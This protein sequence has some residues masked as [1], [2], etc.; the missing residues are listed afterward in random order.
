[1][2][3]NGTNDSPNDED[4]R[5]LRFYETELDKQFEGDQR[6]QS[7]D[8]IVRG[9]PGQHFEVRNIEDQVIETASRVARIPKETG[10]TPEEIRAI[11]RLPDRYR[12]TRARIQQAIQLSPTPSDMGASGG[13]PALAQDSLAIRSEHT[14]FVSDL[15]TAAEST[16]APPQPGTR[17]KHHQSTQSET[18]TN[19]FDSSTANLALRFSEPTACGP[20]IGAQVV[21]KKTSQPNSLASP[22]HST[23]QQISEFLKGYQHTEERSE[24]S[25]ASGRSP[26]SKKVSF[27]LPDE[28]NSRETLRSSEE[29]SFKSA[30]DSL[31]EQEFPSNASGVRTSRTHGSV[32]ARSRPASV[33]ASRP[34]SSTLTSSAT[35]HNRPVSQMLRSSTPHALNLMTHR[36]EPRA[37][38]HQSAQKESLSF[39]PALRQ[40]KPSGSASSSTSSAVQSLSSAPHQDSITLTK[41]QKPKR[42]SS[43]FS[44]QSSRP[45]LFNRVRTRSTR[46]K[47]AQLGG[48]DLQAGEFTR[49]KENHAD[50]APSVLP[51]DGFVESP[52]RLLNKSTA[53]S[54]EQAASPISS[55]SNGAAMGIRVRSNVNT[56]QRSL[57][58][59]APT[60]QSTSSACPSHVS[61]LASRIQSSAAQQLN[62]Q[63]HRRR[64]SHTTTHIDWNDHVLRDR[65]SVDATGPGVLFSEALEDTTTDLRLP[66][67]RYPCGPDYLPAVKEESHEDSSLNTSASNL[68]YSRL[69]LPFS[70]R[71]S[72][73]TWNDE[74]TGH[75]RLS[76]ASHAQSALGTGPMQSRNLPSMDFSEMNLIEKV[77]QEL[78]LHDSMPKDV[79]TDSEEPKGPE[80]AV[81]LEV[82]VVAK[83]SPESCNSLPKESESEPKEFEKMLE[84]TRATSIMTTKQSPSRKTMTTEL[85]ELRVPSVG[86]LGQNISRMLSP[87]RKKPQSSS[88]Q[89][90]FED[91]NEIMEHAMEEIREVG[92]PSQKRSSA[93]LRPMPGSPHLVVMKDDV[94]EE[95]YIKEK[96]NNESN[97]PGDRVGNLSAGEAAFGIKTLSTTRTPTKPHPKAARTAS[98]ISPP[99][100]ATRRRALTKSEQ[101]LRAS[102]ETPFPSLKSLRSLGSLNPTPTVTDTRPWNFDKNYPW[103][104]KDPPIDIVLPPFGSGPHGTISNASKASSFSS[105]DT[106]ATVSP[107]GTTSHSNTQGRRNPFSN[108]SRVGDQHH[109]AGERY[110]TSALTPP[111]AIFRDP[112]SAFDTSDDEDFDTTRKQRTGLRKRFS[113]ARNTN[114]HKAG[115]TVLASPESGE[116]SANSFLR[117]RANEAQ[118]FTAKRFTFRNAEGMQ[119]A[120]Y[121]RKKIVFTI[122]IWCAQTAYL[123]RKIIRRE[124]PD[125]ESENEAEDN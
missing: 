124:R 63:E 96:E 43:I 65:H 70:G 111:T 107:F 41:T 16:R 48:E 106:A 105:A 66:S 122:S 20:E 55:N 104:V 8:N 98:K 113:S 78:G 123:W 34:S 57:S 73:G 75:P 42:M 60:L 80:E 33:L 26:V 28:K 67:Y 31:S 53:V 15:P 118:A 71:Q 85:D 94:Y 99:P 79:L 50:V 29:Q 30:P 49:S 74:A 84:C 47:T 121:Y 116:H 3:G 4:T 77:K 6:A 44:R 82:A 22:E 101:D 1:M 115:P 86:T 25:P 51:T 2:V 119:S 56:Q 100:A 24:S 46:E 38:N 23:G 72:Q 54:E 114:R 35:V 92:G 102:L 45:S 97:H 19:A 64:E 90:E 37:L 21:S 9:I 14:P 7:G 93:R 108:L 11:L 61:F 59:S 76:T 32:V 109:A 58:S 112:S 88:D 5:T 36:D 103:T 83:P 81:Q 17:Q 89:G 12:L 110:P 117:E 69:K 91:E 40:K 18:L 95:C 125:Y 39:Y 68:K 13:S 27:Q 62:H 52:E 10:P 87:L 120:S